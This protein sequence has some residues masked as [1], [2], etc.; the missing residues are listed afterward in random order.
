[1]AK[2]LAAALM[3]VV[4]IDPVNFDHVRYEPGETIE[5]LKPSQARQLIDGGH[6]RPVEVEAAADA[7]AEA[8]AAEKLAADARAVAEVKAATAKT[9]APKAAAKK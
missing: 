5:G 4:C 1:M 3:T 9:A 6:V 7:D 2:L 8:L